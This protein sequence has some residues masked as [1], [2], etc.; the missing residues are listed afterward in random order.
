MSAI[1]LFF[2]CLGNYEFSPHT[3]Y[4]GQDLNRKRRR[5]KRQSSVEI[6]LWAQ[7]P[8]PLLS[9]FK[10]QAWNL[11]DERDIEKFG[12][13]FRL[14]SHNLNNANYK[15]KATIARSEYAYIVSPDLKSKNYTQRRI[16]NLDTLD[17]FVKDHESASYCRFKRLL[18]LIC[19][20][21]EFFSL[22]TPLYSLASRKPR[23]MLVLTSTSAFLKATFIDNSYFDR[24][25]FCRTALS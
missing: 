7:H 9:I 22:Y 23:S 12:L 21:Q 4:P 8:P 3:V 17:E 19:H 13:Y 1:L 16:I 2:F 14:D 11:P 24:M 10:R 5:A 25:S 6:C 15:H 20:H 18:Y